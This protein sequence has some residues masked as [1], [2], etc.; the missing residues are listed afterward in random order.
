MM[1]FRKIAAASVGKLVATYFSETSPDARQWSPEPGKQQQAGRSVETGSRISSYYAEKRAIVEWRRDMDPAIAKR[2]GINSH[3]TPRTDELARLFET[4]RADTGE[5]WAGQNRKISAYDL[6]ISPHKSVTLAAEFA[7][8]K[9]ETGA[10]RFAVKRAND[11]TMR[12]VARELGWARKGKHGLDGADPG[13]VAWVSFFHHTARPTL[14]IE[15]GATGATHLAELPIPGDPQDHIHNALFNIVVTADGRVGSLDTQRLHDRVHEF[16]AYFQAHLAQFLREYGVRVELDV[17]GEAAVLPAIPQQAVVTFSKA[18]KQVERS[19]KAY[20]KRQGL[21]WDALS[22]DAKSTILNASEIAARLPKLRTATEREIWRAQ[23]EAIGWKHETAFE[24]LEAAMFT[25]AERH[26]HA[27]M[28]AARKLAE[29]FKTAAVIDYDKLRLYAARGLIEVGIKGPHE[30]DDVVDVIQQ[31]GITIN[32][33]PAALITGMSEVLSRSGDTIKKLRVTHTEQVDLEE[34]VLAHAQRASRSFTGALSE[35]EIGAAIEASGLDFNREPKHGAAQL[36]AIHALG[37]GADLNLLI[38]VAGAGKTTLLKPLVAAYQAQGRNVIGVATAWRQA[39][40]LQETGIKQGAARAGTR[41]SDATVFHEA[42]VTGTYALTRFLNMVD[43]S[44]LVI[45]NRTV[46]IVDEISQ[47]A[48]KPFLRLLELQAKTGMVIKAIGDPEQVQTIEA[49][50][51]IRLLHGVIPKESIPTL[52]NTVRQATARDRMIA[53]LFRIGRADAALALKR[54]DGTARLIGGDHGQV[55][56]RIASFY[57]DRRDVLLAAGSTRGI[58]ILVLTNEDAAEISRAVR[59]R[60]RERGEIG[61]DFATFEAIDQRGETYQLPLAAG[62]SVRLF[63]KTWADLAGGARGHIGS[64]GDI[65]RVEAVDAHGLTLTNK[66]RQTGRVDWEKLRDRRTGQLLLGFGHAFTIDGAQGV[67]LDEAINALPRGTGSATG[68]K[69]YTAESRH[70]LQAWTL[71]AEAALH[72]AV[73][74]RQALGETTEI[75]TEDLWAQA[76]RDMGYKPYKPNAIDLEDRI[77]RQDVND[78]AIMRIEQQ[79]EMAV[80][81]GGTINGAFHRR[82]EEKIFAQVLAERLP[83]L[84]AALDRRGEAISELADAIDSMQRHRPAVTKY[85]TTETQ[86]APSPSGPSPG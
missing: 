30:I 85:A 25:D 20:A 27:Y 48:P 28:F 46:L 43:R 39:D 16:G 76:A 6:T 69:M 70:V 59:A 37:K 1:A 13:S 34:A 66:E 51:T 79:V 29:E 5:A 15:D 74:G 21:D 82:R 8:V 7:A 19:A 67:T 44:E 86:A 61:A 49:G 35:T 33:K 41:G 14:H 47:I 52:E 2:L 53:G 17:K 45:D 62:D 83:E 40:A 4:K 32:D 26:E 77:Q 68:F 12:Y 72:E 71:I 81:A 78:A 63:R 31:R 73:K 10:I 84:D 38:G 22:F 57:L 24:G 58:G 60:L 55:V 50:D 64:N 36:A 65:L 23:A 18:R 3:S 9:S 75:T 42:G 11:A 56:E 54:E 80:R